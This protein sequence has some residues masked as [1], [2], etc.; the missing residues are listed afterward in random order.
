MEGRRL[1]R[2]LLKLAAV[3]VVPLPNL[4]VKNDS[5]LE[6]GA[7][8]EPLWSAGSAVVERHWIAPEVEVGTRSVPA[9]C[10]AIE[11]ALYLSTLALCSLSQWARKRPATRAGMPPARSLSLSL[12]L[13]SRSHGGCGAKRCA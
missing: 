6:E 3:A 9:A 10:L 1:E 4:S 8:S 5:G 11:P 2:K 7:A 12:S 13:S